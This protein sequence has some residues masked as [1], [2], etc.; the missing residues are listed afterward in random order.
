MNIVLWVLQIALSFLCI[1]GGIFQ[2]FKL[3]DLSKGVAAM[4]ALPRGLWM[5]LGAVGCLGGLC[6]V[7]PGATNLLPI[8]TPL[9][10][11]AVA[12]QSTL[13]S[14]L[15]LRYRDRAPLPYSVTMVLMAA[16]ICYGRLALQP[17]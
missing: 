9:A 6:L 14:G 16:F 13:I 5:A 15:Y 12:A 8:L 11:A 2:I 7:L 17:L 10:A 4:R 1:S 3:R